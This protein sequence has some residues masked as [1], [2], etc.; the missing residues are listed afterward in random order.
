MGCA[1]GLK[2]SLLTQPSALSLNVTSSESTP[3]P[4]VVGPFIVQLTSLIFLFPL[5]ESLFAGKG[6]MFGVFL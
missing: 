1:L 4:A 2:L 3:P 5:K 6:G